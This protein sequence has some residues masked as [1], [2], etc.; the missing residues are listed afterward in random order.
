MELRGI[1]NV[2]E[3]IA[4]HFRKPHA[5]EDNLKFITQGKPCYI[6]SNVMLSLFV[7]ISYI[8]H[9]QDS[10]K[11]SILDHS[12][13]SRLILKTM[14]SGVPHHLRKKYTSLGPMMRMHNTTYPLMTTKS[15]SKRMFAVSLLNLWATHCSRDSS[16]AH[17]HSTFR[18]SSFPNL[19]GKSSP[20]INNK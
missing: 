14:M 7:M 8:K 19:S 4:Q 1:P 5:L 18:R 15:F 16:K 6:Q 20:K 12:T 2:H 17:P 3:V 10:A 13:T 9:R 11:T